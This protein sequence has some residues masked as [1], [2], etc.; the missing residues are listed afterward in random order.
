MLAV[1]YS[2]RTMHPCP[3]CPALAQY[4]QKSSTSSVRTS[5]ETRNAI[6][7]QHALISTADGVS[8]PRP[9]EAVLIKLHAKNNLHD[10][11]I[12]PIF[13]VLCEFPLVGVT[14]YR[15]YNLYFVLN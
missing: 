15:I 2:N 12:H 9:A 5:G 3:R 8:M 14:A 7:D 1:K 4:L 10:Q 6:N 11:H 13:Q